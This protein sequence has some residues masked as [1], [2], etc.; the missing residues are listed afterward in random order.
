VDLGDEA[1]YNN[2]TFPDALVGWCHL[3][4]P[5][6]LW[7]VMKSTQNF[8]P[9]TGVGAP[10]IT[11]RNVALTDGSTTEQLQAQVPLVE[12]YA[13]QNAAEIQYKKAIARLLDLLAIPLIAAVQRYLTETGTKD[14]ALVAANYF[15]SLRTLEEWVAEVAEGL[16]ENPFDGWADYIPIGT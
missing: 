12:A 14:A 6:A 1:V 5:R 10:L 7:Y 2:L 11:A 16:A 3:Y 9:D 15:R 4:P 8:L 13:G